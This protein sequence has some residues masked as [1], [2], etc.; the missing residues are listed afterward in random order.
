MRSSPNRNERAQW[1]VLSVIADAC[2]QFAEARAVARARARLHRCARVLLGAREAICDCAP[3]ARGSY[4][5]HRGTTSAPASSARSRG[6][7]STERPRLPPET[8]TASWSRHD[9]SM[10]VLCRV[11]CPRGLIPPT[12]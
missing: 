2:H 8:T 6:L 1:A 10:K 3:A 7:S 9:S 12:T 5:T 11:V 4:W